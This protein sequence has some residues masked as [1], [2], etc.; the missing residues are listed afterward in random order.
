VSYA[1]GLVAV[2][3]ITGT[4][5]RFRKVRRD[6]LRRRWAPLEDSTERVSPSFRLVESDHRPTTSDA[7][8][9]RPR[10][11]STTNYV[12][13]EN[14]DESPATIHVHA[15]NNRALVRASR[16]RRARPGLVWI[17]A[18]VVLAVV[19]YLVS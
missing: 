1:L 10:I 6:A 14:F 8:I 18:G 19:V 13:G 7:P 12:F 2:L 15:R 5:L 3:A 9:Q 17:G 4:W 16:R 11:D